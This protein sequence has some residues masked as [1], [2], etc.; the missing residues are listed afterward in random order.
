MDADEPIPAG[1][2][3]IEG[4]LRY[5]DG[6]DW[7]DHIAPPPQPTLSKREIAEGVLLGIVLAWFLLRVA[8]DVSPDTFFL[9]VKFVVDEVPG[10]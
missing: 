1:W 4:T 8:A 10:L 7:T 6:R 9:P 5:H 2:H 3:D